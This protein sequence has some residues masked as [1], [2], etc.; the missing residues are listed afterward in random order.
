MKDLLSEAPTLAFYDATKRTIVIA[1]ASSYGMGGVLLQG[2]NGQLKSVAYCSCT[3]TPAEK[4]YAQ[5]EK[6]CLAMVWACEKFERYLVVLGSFSALTDYRPLAALVNTKDLQETPLRCQRLL[7][8]LRRY[9]VTAEYA[10]GKDMV[11]ADALSRSPLNRESG[12][13]L[14]QYVQDHDNEITSSWSASESK[15]SQ[16]R[17]ET[18]KDLNLKT[19]M[20]YTLIG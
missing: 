18:Q 5:I 6:E 19:A 10:P 9:N 16:I 20:E 1:D 7:M 3:L 14:Q 11:V 17:K 2:H 12:N 8:R 15:L 4:G 13:H